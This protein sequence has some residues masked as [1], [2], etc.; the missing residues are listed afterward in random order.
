LSGATNW[1]LY[2]YMRWA[3]LAT[4]SIALG[5]LCSLACADWPLC[6]ESCGDGRR[7]IEA[8]CVDDPCQ[9]WECGDDGYGGSCG[10]CESGVCKNHVCKNC[11]DDMVLIPKGTGVENRVCIDR[12]EASLGANDKAMSQKGAMPTTNISGDAAKAACINSEKRLCVGEEWI[13]ACSTGPLRF[14]GCSA[15]AE[16]RPRPDRIPAARDR[17]R[18]KRK[19]SC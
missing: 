19:A 15:R 16:I 14:S 8:R 13:A 4:L 6:D 11:P 12:Y 7:C 9:N 3:G 10:S 17:A 5:S 18:A 2:R 1:P